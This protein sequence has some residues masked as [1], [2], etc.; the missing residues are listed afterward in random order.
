MS[1]GHPSLLDRVVR[2]S[3]DPDGDLYGDERERLRWYEGIA[4]AANLQWVALP[5]AAAILVWLLGRSAV[6]PLAVVLAV[7]Y[8]P[9]VLCAA[10]VKRRRVDTAVPR[11]S[12]K[13][14]VLT[15]LTIVPYVL[16][17][18]GACY[19][20]REQDPDLYRGA[21][22]GGVFGGALGITISI[23]Q[24]RRRRRRE[25]AQIGDED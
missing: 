2:W 9:M 8:L 10:Y 4:T 17:I 12:A 22:I 21:A 6:L 25:A 11:W 5:W 23:V 20:Y 1:S 14:I 3:L 13:R 7:L 24:S 19:A 16:F 15:I 18:V